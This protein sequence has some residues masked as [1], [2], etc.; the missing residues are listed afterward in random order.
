MELTDRDRLRMQ[1]LHS[2]LVAVLELAASEFTG[3]EGW[4]I[5]EGRRSLERQKELYAAGR[6][7]T[8]QSRHLTGHAVDIYPI[9]ERPI[10]EMAPEDF[11]F[12]NLA[13]RSAA[14][15]LQVP[16][17]H[18]I[19]WGWDAPHHELDAAVFPA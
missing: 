4:F 9:S 10:P 5:S 13:V 15:K 1:G 8:L 6:T 16:M 3:A 2:Q 12:I 7:K 17:K 19:D 18:G 14:L 11:D